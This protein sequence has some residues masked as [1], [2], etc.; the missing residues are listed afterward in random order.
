MSDKR[1]M[2]GKVKRDRTDTVE[3]G[4]WETIDGYIDTQ[5]DKIDD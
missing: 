1:N 4:E 2:K 5:M 3:S